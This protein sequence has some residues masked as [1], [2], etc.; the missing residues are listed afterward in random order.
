[1]KRDMTFEV[2]TTV[3]IK[4][5]VFYSLTVFSLTDRFEQ[6]MH[7]L[8]NKI[9]FLVTETKTSTQYQNSQTIS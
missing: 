4:T 9:N 7:D 1:M 5:D 6:I 2:L 8:R 3:N